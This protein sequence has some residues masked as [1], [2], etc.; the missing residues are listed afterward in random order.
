MQKGGT[1]RENIKLK[2]TVVNFS[3]WSLSLKRKGDD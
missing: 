2:V 3:E 1:I